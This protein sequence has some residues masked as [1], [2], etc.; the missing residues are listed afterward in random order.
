MKKL[1]ISTVLILAF[2]L[3]LNGQNSECISCN[4][5]TID[6]ANYSSAVGSENIST[7]LN[8]FAAGYSNLVEGD[9]SSA[10][11]LNHLVTSEKSHAIGYHDSVS[12]TGGIAIGTG[13]AVTDQY[14]IAIGLNAKAK[15][16]YSISIGDRAITSGM[17][18]YAFGYHIWSQAQ[19][20][21][22]IGTGMTSPVY[23][24][25][26]QSYSLMVGFFSDLPTLFVGSSSGTGTTGKI[27][28]GNITSPEAK[29]HIKADTNEDADIKLEPGNTN[30]LSKIIFKDEDHIIS[31][32]F[33]N[34]FTFKAPAS[35]PFYFQEGFLG[36]GTDEPLA[37]LQ[38][39]DG[40]IFIEDIN[41]GIIMKS[42]DGNCW[43]GSLNNSGALQ[44][45]QVNCD[46]LTN[47]TVENSGIQTSMAK[48][49][50]NPAGDNVFVSIDPELSG[51]LIE[52]V[53]LSGKTIYSEK[54][55]NTESYIDLRAYQPGMYLFRIAKGNG[56][57]IY[58]I[59]VLKK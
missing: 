33:K 1:M 18:S 44:F 13:V 31:G 23:L 21:I 25:N 10:L 46:D 17:H 29:L 36:I 39:K 47:S 58:S 3:F 9:Y 32:N 48:I 49:Y 56:E 54:L 43:R 45:V 57:N 19:G 27:G 55:Y 14:S 28:I 6:T 51:H 26:D 15:N 5:N 22:T 20:S 16:K 8:S 50:P 30:R 11:G 52:I 4:N 7:G 40:D 41:R 37:K 24:I 53:D 2:A 12:A 38:I 59:K 35:T 42:P 34:G